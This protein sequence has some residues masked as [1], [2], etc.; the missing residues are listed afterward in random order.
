MKFIIIFI[1]GILSACGVGPNSSGGSKDS[2]P[3]V[4]ED[5]AAQAN[6]NVQ[7]DGHETSSELAV[8]VNTMRVQC[9]MSE[10]QVSQR[11]K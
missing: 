7:I 6:C 8:K 1:F 2:S 3:I 5:K 10:E 11:M 4:T 9:G